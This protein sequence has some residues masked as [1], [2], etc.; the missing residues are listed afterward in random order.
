MLVLLE[1]ISRVLKTDQE[2]GRGISGK[3]CKRSGLWISFL[4]NLSW[5]K[6]K[7]DRKKR[8][9]GALDVSVWKFLLRMQPERAA[10]A[11]FRV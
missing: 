7:F 10:G 9:A 1:M 8:H 6:E 2:F 3:C 11:G 5:G 4:M